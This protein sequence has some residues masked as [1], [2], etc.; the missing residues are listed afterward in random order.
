MKVTEFLGL[1]IETGSNVEPLSMLQVA[2]QQQQ[3]TFLS[4]WLHFPSLSYPWHIS[5][6]HYLAQA[7][8][9]LLGV[10]IGDRDQ[11]DSFSGRLETIG[12]NGTYDLAGEFDV[13]VCEYLRL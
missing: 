11:V 12:N 10:W 7:E 13:G 6:L 4:S 3:L 5:R 2:Q 9:R 1:P 8:L